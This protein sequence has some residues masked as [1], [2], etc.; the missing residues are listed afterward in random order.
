[1]NKKINI[2]ASKNMT[3]KLLGIGLD[4]KIESSSKFDTLIRVEAE[5]IKCDLKRRA[6]DTVILSMLLLMVMII[7]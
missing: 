2:L 5:I 7:W 4:L 3:K 6:T 1:M